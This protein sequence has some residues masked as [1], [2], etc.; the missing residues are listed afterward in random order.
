[1][2]R[3]ALVSMT[4]LAAALAAASP[5]AAQPQHKGTCDLTVAKRSEGALVAGKPAKYLITVVNAGTG[6]C[7]GPIVLHDV[8]PAGVSL[9]GAS[10]GWSCN[11]GSCIYTHPQSLPAGSTLTVEL[12]VD[13]AKG[14][15]AVLRNCVSVN[16]GP[17]GP[18]D[19]DSP[20]DTQAEILGPDPGAPVVPWPNLDV[21][22]SNNSACGCSPVRRYCDL[23]V[24][25]THQGSF[26]QGGQGQFVVTVT[27][28]GAAACQGPIWVSDVVPQ[29]LTLIGSTPAVCTTG[30]CQLP[31][32]LAPS[33]S[34]TLVLTFAVSEQAPDLVDNCVR[35]RNDRRPTGV[36]ERL[37]TEPLRKTEV[38]AG[39]DYDSSNNSACDCA[40]TERCPNWTGWLD[41]DDPA[42]TGDWETLK[43]FLSAGQVPC[44]D[45]VAIQCETLQGVPWYLAG[46]VYSCKREVGGVC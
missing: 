2:I 26:I 8:L 28:V 37:P 46:E 30:I 27:N 16:H 21:D 32:S 42:T 9:S 24:T 6:S 7:V 4:V 33:Q 11:G 13:V 34:V 12:P 45:P 1:M 40:P 5:S 41:R 10:S 43:D 3:R 35:V 23:T 44:K 31:G 14:A 15:G 19:S 18:V 25:K 20:S 39:R 38:P 22:R 36:E 17:H 29:G